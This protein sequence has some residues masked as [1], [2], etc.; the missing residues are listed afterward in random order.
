M[1]KTVFS[2]V[3]T[4]RNVLAAGAW[5]RVLF[6]PTTDRIGRL[7]EKLHFVLF[8]FVLLPERE[9]RGRISLLIQ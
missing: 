6:C 8:V 7:K 5:V 3:E 9:K 1:L 4:L 2:R